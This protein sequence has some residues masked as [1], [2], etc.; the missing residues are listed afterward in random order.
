M[1]LE[2]T[3][4]SRR[5][6]RSFTPEPVD[7]DVVD[8]LCDLARRAPSAG[9]TQATAFLVLDT[10]EAVAAYWDQTLQGEARTRFGWPGLLRAPVVVVV[11]VDPDAYVQRY[12]E[13]DKARTGLGGGQERW[14]VPYWWVDAGAVAQNL[15]LAAVD[16]GLGGCLFGLF[17]HEEA[18]RDRFD[19]ADGWRLVA[20]IALGHPDPEG[21]APGRSADRPRP[22]LATV[23]L[24]SRW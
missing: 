9:N 16:A 23:I 20:T 12:A 3:I 24:R 11:C 1:E 7:P 21:S 17:D 10:P 4:R 8:G 13:P 18:V 14:P 5:M 22:D 2:R 19:V 6:V 15:L